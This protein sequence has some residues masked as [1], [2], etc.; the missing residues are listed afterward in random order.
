MPAD[1]APQAVVEAFVV[2][3]PA[4]RGRGDRLADRRR[5]RALVAV[6]GA[7]PQRAATSTR[8][9]ALSW[10][11]ACRSRSTRS[12]AS[13]RA[14]R[15]STSSPGC[16]S[17]TTRATTSR[18]A[19]SCSARRTASS[20][21][22]LFFLAERAKDE[23][24]RI[25]RG[26]RDLLPYA[27]ADSIVAQRRDRGALGRRARADRRASARTW[28]ELA[29]DRDARLARRPRR[30]DRTRLRAS[31]RSWRRRPTPRRSSRCGT[32][33]SCATS[34][35][36]TSR[37]QA[38]STSAASSTTSTRLDEADQDE[39]ELRATEEN[40]VRLLT[41]H[42]AKGLEWDVV[43]L[44]GP[45]EGHHAASG[46]GREQPGRALVSG[47]RSSSAA[48]ATSS[49]APDDEGAARPAPRRG[50]AAAD[51]RRR[52]TR[53]AAGSS[54]RARGTTAT[55]SGRRSRRRSGTRRS[56]PGSCGTRETSTCPPENPHPGGIEPQPEPAARVRAPADRPGRDRAA[57]GAS[58]SACARWRRS[59]P[60]A[61][62]WRV[63]STLSVTAFLTFV[64][65]PDEFFR[66][67]VRRVPVAAL[68]GRE[69]RNRAAPADRAPRARSR[70]RRRPAGGRRGAVRPR[71]R[72]AHGRRRHACQP[73]RCGR[74]SSRAASPR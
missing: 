38:R 58:W 72:R 5:R 66:R 19:G 51:V 18:S 33:R 13:G 56:R 39:D 74:T 40:A 6:R 7:R 68:A 32:W 47:C 41:L 43:F 48:T 27:L 45:R 20:R 61:A 37:S 11:R 15:S 52:H 23:N 46:Q 67:Y 34:P 42:R 24:Y 4:R 73:S 31:P 25:R 53:A 17:S 49:R 21:R 22:D 16:A 10:R 8:S 9:T 36:A 12:A 59:S 1:G 69:A 26:D 62:H 65:D 30:R 63:P 14:P 60:R 55:T 64:R 44:P 54:S 71:P 35:R 57:R 28:R 29:G 70:R 2:A 50:G 3:A